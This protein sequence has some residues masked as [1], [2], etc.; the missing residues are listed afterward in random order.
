ME[1]GFLDRYVDVEGSS[2]H[3]QV[4]VPLSYKATERW[5]V[6]LFLHG[7]GEQG[8][9]GLL[10]TQVGLAAAIRQHSSRYPAIVIFPQAPED[11]L[12]VGTTARMAMAALSKTMEEFQTDA[13]RV[14]LTG[15]S[16]GGNG[17][18]YLA[19]RNPALFAAVVPVCGWV[20]PFKRQYQISETVVPASEKAPFEVLATR[21]A[22]VPIWIFHGEAD[23]SVPVDE[24]RQAAA[25]LTAAG[26]AVKYTELPGVGHN[27]WDAAYGSL[28]F[29][30]C[31]FQQKQ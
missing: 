2:Y 26:A 1:T 28:K 27:S 15:L 7:M 12:W 22:R 11:S 14:Y 20:T 24:S 31:L 30:T 4:Y 19:Y 17:T 13:G 18:W 6:I 25:A 16:M 5:P 10:Q 8:R 9:D 3:Y 29:T 21:L 23:V